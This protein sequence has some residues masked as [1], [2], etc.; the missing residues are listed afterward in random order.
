MWQIR[1]P[2]IMGAASVYIYMRIRITHELVTHLVLSRSM[3]VLAVYGFAVVVGVVVVVSV[4]QSPQSLLE[5]L[6]I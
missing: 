2:K 5:D 6:E 3:H 1:R 4:R